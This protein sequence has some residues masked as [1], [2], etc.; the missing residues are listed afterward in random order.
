[1]AMNQNKGGGRVAGVRIYEFQYTVKL[2]GA[3]SFI[4]W[5]FGAGR[6]AIFHDF[7]IFGQT[8]SF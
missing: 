2:S 4:I 1:M 5:P 8:K 7:T 3:N 6:Q